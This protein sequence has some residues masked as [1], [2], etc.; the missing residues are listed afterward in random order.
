MWMTQEEI[1]PALRSEGGKRAAV[2][3]RLRTE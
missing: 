2:N 1:M 3:N